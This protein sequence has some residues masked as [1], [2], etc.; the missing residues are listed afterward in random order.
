MSKK[1][2]QRDVAPRGGCVRVKAAEGVACLQLSI[3]LE[4]ENG[5]SAELLGQGANAEACIGCKGNLPFEIGV[6]I[7][8]LEDELVI[9]GHGHHAHKSVAMLIERCSSIDAGSHGRYCLRLR[10][11]DSQRNVDG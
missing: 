5:G 7:T 3:L 9:A 2:A 4:Q 8:A 10:R 6:A 1:I 11:R